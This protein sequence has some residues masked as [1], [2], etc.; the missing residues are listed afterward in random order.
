MKKITPFIIV[1]VA[2]LFALANTYGQ[3]L[4]LAKP[5]M[6]DYNVK[7]YLPKIGSTNMED[8]GVLKKTESA[9][10]MAIKLF[11]NQSQKSTL[12]NRSRNA[13]VYQLPIDKMP[14]AVPD[15]SVCY[16][17]NVQKNG[18]DAAENIPNAME[19]Q[20]WLPEQSKK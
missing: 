17:M 9:S 5:Q 12:L 4:K 20:N 2:G 18:V 13:N 19:K 16:K 15:N 7:N 6:N 10:A 14:C 1:C 8:N 3:T 11:S